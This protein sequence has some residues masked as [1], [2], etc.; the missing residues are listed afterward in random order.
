MTCNSLRGNVLKVGVDPCVVFLISLQTIR[1]VL[2]GVNAID[3]MLPR[4]GLENV[5]E[6]RLEIVQLSSDSPAVLRLDFLGCAEGKSLILSS[7]YLKREFSCEKCCFKGWMLLLNGNLLTFV[8]VAAKTTTMVSTVTTTT[9]GPS[10]TTE[11]VKTTTVV[12]PPGEET[13][14]VTTSLPMLSTTPGEVF[15]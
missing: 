11:E 5:I 8:F 1:V 10:I 4:D 3:R 14:T 2:Q 13:T 9:T 6:V 7:I 15:L 12:T